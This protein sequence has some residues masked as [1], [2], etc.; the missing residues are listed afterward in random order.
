MSSSGFAALALAATR[1]RAAA[2]VPGAP[3]GAP[4]PAGRL[5]ALATTAA[6]G[7]IG[8]SDRA[9]AATSSMTAAGGELAIGGGLGSMTAEAMG[10][11]LAAGLA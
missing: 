2:F 9:G 7:A 3:A 11:V 10:G 6:V 1:G 5:F 4:R 8:A